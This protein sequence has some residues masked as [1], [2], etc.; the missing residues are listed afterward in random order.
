MMVNS[1]QLAECVATAMGKPP[2]ST[3]QH[4]KNLREAKGAKE[5]GVPLVTAGGRG[6]NAPTMSRKDAA[7]LIC[8]ILGSDA[9]QDSVK[10]VEWMR[11][12][13]PEFH[14]YRF[15]RPY[16]RF[17][18]IADVE[19][20]IRPGH[21]VVEALA[22][23]LEFF[24]REAEY[25]TAFEGYRP[26]S[27]DIYF[28]LYVEFPQRFVSLTFGVRRLVSAAW[29]YGRRLGL[30]DKQARWIEQDELREI[31]AITKPPS[32]ELPKQ[33]FD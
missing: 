11:D 6:R 21:D 29:T 7:T 27:L 3:A 20:G 8:A 28:R 17:W 19:I 30:P 31:A 32:N 33:T 12:L 23:V 5:E 25:K 22:R 16:G 10:T 1:R 2:T 4:A 13:K 14:G 24:D 26:A 15:R 18:R 9:V